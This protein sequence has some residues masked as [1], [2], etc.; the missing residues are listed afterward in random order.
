MGFSL[1]ARHVSREFNP[2]LPL[3]AQECVPAKRIEPELAIFR[4]FDWRTRKDESGN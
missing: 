3:L 2:E 1:L 4:G